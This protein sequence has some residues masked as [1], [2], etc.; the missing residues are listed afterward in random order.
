MRVI[1]YKKQSMKVNYN[2]LS[3]NNFVTLSEVLSFREL[4]EKID[5]QI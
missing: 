1:T 3:Q 4:D 5:C 2:L